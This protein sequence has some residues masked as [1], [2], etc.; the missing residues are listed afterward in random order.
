MDVYV[1]LQRDD[2]KILLLERANTGYA[3]GQ[4]CPPSG[5]LEADETVADGAIRE[6]KEEVGVL[7]EPSALRFTHVIHY[8]SPEGQG[9][10]GFFFTA[11][12]WRGEPVNQEP[13]K[14]A[15]LLWA[16]PSDPPAN[17]VSYTALAL[18]QITNGAA[19]SVGGW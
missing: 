9:R 6:A 14:C 1:L 11:N 4:L 19:F 2:G 13:H 10:I 17:T 5:H 15:R 8:R 3:D 7:I 18:A 12:A 16:D